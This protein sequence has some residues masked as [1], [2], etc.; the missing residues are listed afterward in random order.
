MNHHAVN[1][2]A[3][4]GH[5][6][7]FDFLHG[8]WRIDNRR[9]R[10]RWVGADDWES[11]EGFSRCAPYLGGGA[12]IEQLDLP[13]LGFSGLS[14][15]L[16]DPMSHR[17]AIHWVDTEHGAL[18][19]PLHGGF[20]G[21]HGAFVGRSQDEGVPVTVQFFWT[22]LDTDNA[23]WSQAFSRDGIVWETNWIMRLTRA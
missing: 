11:F 14:L 2:A 8:D 5:P 22:R 10:R 3:P 18:F 9:L 21:D 19:P 13:A 1:F 4:S 23:R 15:R 6:H 17:W 7:D 12:N 16:F 20:V